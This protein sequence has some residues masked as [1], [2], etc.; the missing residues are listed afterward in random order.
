[1]VGIEVLRTNSFKLAETAKQREAAFSLGSAN[2][3]KITFWDIR[4]SGSYIK[5]ITDLK[6]KMVIEL[7]IQMFSE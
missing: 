3:L 7:I 6:T 5:G 4:C 1:M 2:K